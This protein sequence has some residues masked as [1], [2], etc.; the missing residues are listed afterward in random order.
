MPGAQ[1][2]E[3]GIAAARDGDDVVAEQRFAEAAGAFTGVDDDLGHWW[4]KPAEVLPVVGHNARAI[5]AMASTAA[6]VSLRGEAA[7]AD[8]DVD[9]LTVSGGRL[10]LDRVRALER[11]L[12][13]VAATLERARPGWTRSRRRGWCRRSPTA[14]TGCRRRS[15]TP[16]PM[17]GWRPM[18]CG[19]VPAIFGGE[20]E[21]RWLVAFTTP[22]EARG[23]SGFMGHYAELTAVDGDVDMPRFG[24]VHELEQGGAPAPE[25]TL[26][27]PTDYLAR[28]GRYLPSAPWRNITMSPDFPSVGRV[29][30]ELYPQSSGRPVDG[31]IAVDPTALAALLEF[32]GPVTVPG[33]PEPLTAEN[34]AD[35]MLLD[36]YVELPD[37]GQRVDVLETL[38]R[39][40]FER[41][42]SGDLPGPRTVADTLGP[43]VRDGHIQIYGTHGDQQGLFTE[44][45]AD[46]AFP[47]SKVTPGR[48]HQQRDREQDRPLPV[49]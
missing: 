25:R 14:S 4:A 41:L 2:L 44:I 31:V 3:E 22:V 20:R 6:D 15:L 36:Q 18:R 45:G 43:S 8:A 21:A 26:S 34:A 38:A 49:A 27:G 29:M 33:V 42:T 13:E 32:T 5:H 35:F 11:P 24:R 46:G 28:W 37:S 17:R 23:R 30:T 16:G 1:Q 10:D 7:A 40:T 48:G 19:V 47:G 12:V 39:T 9:Q